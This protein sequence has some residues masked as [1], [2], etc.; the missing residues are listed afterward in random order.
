[1]TE[2]SLITL[3]HY[4]YPYAP[5]PPSDFS[6]QKWKNRMCRCLAFSQ[7]CGTKKIWLNSPSSLRLHHYIRLAFSSFPQMLLVLY[8]DPFCLR[9]EFFHKHFMVLLAVLKT[10]NVEEFPKCFQ[11]FDSLCARRE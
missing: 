6:F 2:Y 4:L 9:P 11:V 7:V 1:M 10:E 5:P 8:L 3:V